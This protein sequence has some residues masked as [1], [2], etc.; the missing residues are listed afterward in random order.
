[1]PEDLNHNGNL[2]GGKAMAWA[3]IDA[4]LCASLKFPKANFVT[5]HFEA[6]NFLAPSTLGDILE[7]HCAIQEIGNTSV[8]VTVEAKNTKT[9]NPI[10]S[11]KAVFVNIKAGKKSSILA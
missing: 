1:M 11:T 3:D 4:F 5:R 2:F 6:F 8:S 9:G 7:I 10:F